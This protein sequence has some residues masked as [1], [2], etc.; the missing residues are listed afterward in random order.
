MDLLAAADFSRSCDFLFFDLGS[1]LNLELS[2]FVACRRAV[3]EPSVSFSEFML[4][5]ALAAESV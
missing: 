4:A 5:V 2:L 1:L 3:V